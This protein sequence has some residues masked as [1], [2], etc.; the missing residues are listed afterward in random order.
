M[1]AYS[2]NRISKKIVQKNTEPYSLALGWYSYSDNEP[3]TIQEILDM[4]PVSPK[5]NINVMIGVNTFTVYYPHFIYRVL[6]MLGVK[7]APNSTVNVRL[8][9]L[10]KA[11]EWSKK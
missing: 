8:R 9:L 2:P 6:V 1:G 5:S 11:L 4:C 7:S 3:V 10:N